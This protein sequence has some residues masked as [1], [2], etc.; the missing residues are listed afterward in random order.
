MDFKDNLMGA[1]GKQYDDGITSDLR[2]T[3]MMQSVVQA[4]GLCH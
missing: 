3:T 1:R 4:A 2:R